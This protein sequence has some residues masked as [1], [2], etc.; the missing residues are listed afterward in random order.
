[1]GY[2]DEVI[3]A[4]VLKAI[5]PGNNI[6][7]YLECKKNLTVSSL[8]D[9][10]RSHFREKDSSTIF[11]ELSNAS[12]EQNE[13]CLDFVV[14]V[15]CLRQRVFDIGEEEGCVYEKKFVQTRFLHTLAVG[16]RNSNIRNEIR[17]ILNKID[18]SDEELLKSVTDAVANETERSGKLSLKKREPVVS[19]VEAASAATEKPLVEKRKKENHLQVQIQELKTNQEKELAA[20]KNDLREIKSA[21]TGNNFGL[22]SA[23]RSDQHQRKDGFRNFNQQKQYLPRKSPKCKTCETN[24]VSR[25][26]HCLKCGSTDHRIA[27]CQSDKKNDE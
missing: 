17:D 1:M 9:V 24:N 20:L 15:M 25:C 5:S 3:C 6:R 14:R 19:A 23:C 21:L 7:T 26:V 2:G 13:N 4:G 16:I 12:Q 11:T 18:I 8:L 10:L 22:N 27:Q